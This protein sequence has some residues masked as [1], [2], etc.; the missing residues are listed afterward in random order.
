MCGCMVGVWIVCVI[1]KT[2]INQVCFVE[3]FFG[4]VFKSQFV[5]HAM[6]TN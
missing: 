2:F 6:E 1:K 5:I 4:L 3:I